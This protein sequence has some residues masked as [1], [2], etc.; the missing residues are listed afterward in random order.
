[1]PVINTTTLFSTYSTQ[2]LYRVQCGRF[3]RC[4]ATLQPRTHHNQ[5]MPILRDRRNKELDPSSKN[6]DGLNYH[7]TKKSS[8]CYFSSAA[9]GRRPIIIIAV[10][11]IVFVTSFQQQNTKT[12]VYVE[13]VKAAHQVREGVQP[14]SIDPALL[15]KGDTRHM[16]APFVWEHILR[17]GRQLMDDEKTRNGGV[18][19]LK[20]LVA[21]EVGANT[22]SDAMQM[23]SFG[24]ETH[25]F[26]PSPRSFKKMG[27]RWTKSYKREIVEK[28][29]L[30][31]YAVGDADGGKILFD[32]SGSTGAAV[33]SEEAAAKKSFV[34]HVKTMTMDTF[35][36]GKVQPDVGFQS[37]SSSLNGKI[38]AAKI[39][40]QGFEPKVFDGMKDSIFQRK[41]HFILT[42]YDPM[43]VDE[44]NGFAKKCKES[45]SYISMMHEAGYRIYALKLV[46]HP[47]NERGWEDLKNITAHQNRPFSDAEEDCLNMHRLQNEI[48][49]DLT[50]HVWT[51][52]LAVSPDAPW[53]ENV[54]ELIG[55][56]KRNENRAVK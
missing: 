12:D 13:R 19:P 42:E 52:F 27:R 49:K 34:A 24:F 22:L 11:I 46:T 38:F 35:F 48:Y 5:T 10:V 16:D 9:A 2:T 53:P 28:I 36:S 41:I 18:D 6:A 51:D 55:I 20:P 39:D 44:V 17:T 26:E 1:M 29:F 31:N 25:S 32:N 4:T 40:V 33:L 23:A 7:G 3:D 21:V 37:S 14:F 43:A 50:F 47:K 30:Y 15:M 45:L 8:Q 56:I 54:S